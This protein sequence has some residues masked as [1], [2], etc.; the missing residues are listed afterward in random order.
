MIIYNKLWDT[1]KAKGFSQYRLVE[2]YKFSR[3]Q[4]SRLRHNKNVST[5][6]LNTL[7][8]ILKCDLSDIAEYREDIIETKNE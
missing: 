3:G 4:L 7:C 6:T 8:R 5:N 1:M 2:E